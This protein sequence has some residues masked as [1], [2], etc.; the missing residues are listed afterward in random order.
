MIHGFSPDH[1]LMKGCME[2]IFDE[3]TGW[4][5][6]YIDLPGKGRTKD[7]KAIRHSDGMLQAVIDFIDAVI[8]NQPYL[9]VGESYGGYLTR[10]VIRQQSEKIMGVA[11]ICRM[12]IPEKQHRTLPMHTNIFSDSEFLT[13]LSKAERDDFASRK[14]MDFHLV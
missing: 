6:I 9:L 8:P 4:R 11:F 12:I 7:Y 1:R 10:G 14:T 2:P 3:R 13:K 5:R